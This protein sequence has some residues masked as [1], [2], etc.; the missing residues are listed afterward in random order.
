MSKPL[1]DAISIC[2]TIM[3]NGFDAY[4]INAR[5]QE[6]ILESGGEREVDICSEAD[7]EDLSK[8]F[9]LFEV[10]VTPD[11]TGTLKENDVLIRVYPADAED[12]SYP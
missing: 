12:G 4:V 2:K 11:I 7:F 10:P 5:L 3:R 8:L 9:P 1:K 6:K